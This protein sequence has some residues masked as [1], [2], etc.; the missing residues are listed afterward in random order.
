MAGYIG[1]FSRQLYEPA[2]EPGA[3]AYCKSTPTYVLLIYPYESR[4][5]LPTDGNPIIEEEFN[6]AA[7]P[8]QCPRR[9]SS[10]QLAQCRGSIFPRSNTY[11][12]G[13]QVYIVS[14][15]I[16]GADEKTKNNGQRGLQGV[17]PQHWKTWRERVK[18]SV[19]RISQ[20]LPGSAVPC[21]LE[22]NGLAPSTP[23]LSSRRRP[24]ALVFVQMQLIG[25]TSWTVLQHYSQGCSYY[26]WQPVG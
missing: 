13:R 3:W 25:V 6:S 1:E 2:K 16:S 24:A 14:I 23:A 8:A 5:W 15:R 4:C 21:H 22:A 18:I 10:G 12:H 9:R 17:W 7:D 19:P 20:R 11:G 26:F